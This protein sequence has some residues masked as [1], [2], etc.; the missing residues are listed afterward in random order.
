ML[1]T[2]TDRDPGLNSESDRAGHHDAASDSDDHQ[3]ELRLSEEW[4]LGWPL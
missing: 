3:L 4:R 1:Q 2:F